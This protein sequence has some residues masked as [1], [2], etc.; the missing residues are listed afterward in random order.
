MLDVTNKE[1]KEKDSAKLN[2][3]ERNDDGNSKLDEAR[4]EISGAKPNMMMSE[5][6]EDCKLQLSFSEEIECCNESGK[7]DE[8]S[9][10]RKM[11][12]ILTIRA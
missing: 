10:D 12:T 7:E 2:N 11:D 9:H 1:S 5:S 8:H 3:L 6:K 4:I